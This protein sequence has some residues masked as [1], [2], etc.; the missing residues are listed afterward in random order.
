[1]ASHTPASISNGSS[2][3][4]GT[5]ISS[6]AIATMTSP[7][8]AALITTLCPS[9]ISPRRDGAFSAALTLQRASY[10]RLRISFCNPES[11]LSLSLEDHAARL[12]A[13]RSRIRRSSG[14][15][16]CR[17]RR[18]LEGHPELQQQPRLFCA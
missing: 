11:L 4:G 3:H 7:A 9:R 10:R 6:V 5:V 2:H 14:Y 17:R 16:A 13:A 1:S 8:S 15:S 12:G 18:G